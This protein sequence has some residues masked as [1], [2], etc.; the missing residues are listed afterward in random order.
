MSA[1]PASHTLA[2]IHTRTGVAL[3]QLGFFIP[4]GYSLIHTHTHTHIYPTGFLN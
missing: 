4:W 2:R 3:L 1:P